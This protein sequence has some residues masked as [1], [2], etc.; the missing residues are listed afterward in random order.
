MAN[1]QISQ[2]PSWS[3]T[4]ADS[5]WFV[6]NNAAENETFKYQGFASPIRYITNET[7]IQNVYDATAK[8]NGDYQI[9]IGGFDNNIQSTGVREGIFGGYVNTI[10]SKAQG[11]GSIIVGGGNNIIG[12]PSDANCNFGPAIF[13]SNSAENNAY[14]SA[15]VGSYAPSGANSIIRRGSDNNN[16]I[17]GAF[18]GGGYQI[19]IEQLALQSFGIGGFTN[20][21]RAANS[22]VIGGS[23]NLIDETN[24]GYDVTRGRNVIIGG[25]N[26]TIKNSNR[27]NII[28]GTGSTI[29][30]KENIQMIGTKNRTGTTDNTV[31]VENSH[32]FRTYSTEVQV[33]SSGTTFTVNLNN[34]GKPQIY[35][36]GAAT[37]DFTGVRDGQSFI[38]KTQTNGGHTITWSST[39]YTFLW[40]G[41][42]STP[43]NNKIDLWRFEVFG[44][45]IYGEKVADFS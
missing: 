39:G 7:R 27:S 33:V 22:G 38:L 18:I 9:N 40:K 24:T 42:D 2:L 4:A 5:R 23:N 36:T 13:G 19:Y 45:V 28:G 11:Y 17:A 43:S 6:M 41:A 16:G 3:G 34:G 37:V 20:T 26:N 8:V 14:F 35:I 44:T 32:A 1:T 29:D 21:I 12:G 30:T 10:S 31:Y 15:I 25:N